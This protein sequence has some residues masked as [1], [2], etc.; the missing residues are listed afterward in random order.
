M[1][2]ITIVDLLFYWTILFLDCLAMM[3]TSFSSSDFLIWI[4]IVIDCIIIFARLVGIYKS[5]HN[6]SKE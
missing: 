1:Y 2:E 4:A 3:P 6:E 5:Q